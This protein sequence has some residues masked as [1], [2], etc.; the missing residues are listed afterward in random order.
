[1]ACLGPMRN[2]AEAALEPA[3]YKSQVRCPTGSATTPLTYAKKLNIMKLEPG[4]GAGYAKKCIRPILQ[5]KGPTLGL[6][7]K[8]SSYKSGKNAPQSH[9][10][11]V[12]LPHGHLLICTTKQI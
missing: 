3:T 8:N 1:M 4:L 9:A 10:V 2:G 12:L 6:Y 7:V 11:R 5:L